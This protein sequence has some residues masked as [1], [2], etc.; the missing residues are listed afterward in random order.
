MIVTLL[1]AVPP[2]P[3]AVMVYVVVTV[4]DTLIDPLE[5]TVPTSGWIS[6][7][8]ASVE[9]QVRV[10][11]PPYGILTG[12]AEIDTVGGGVGGVTVIVALALAVPPGPV[13]VMV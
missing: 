11:D 5:P 10:A 9:V 3:V 7:A 13:T 1:V 12:S 6:H 4:G 8:S 2:V